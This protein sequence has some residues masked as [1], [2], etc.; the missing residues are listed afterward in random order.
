MEDSPITRGKG[1]T[2]KTIRKTIRKDLG[3]NELDPNMVYD[4]TLQRNLIHVAN[5][6]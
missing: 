1:R 4:K 3:I 6:T 5:P 2:R